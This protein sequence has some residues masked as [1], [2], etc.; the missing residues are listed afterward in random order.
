MGGSIDV[1]E[2]KMTDAQKLRDQFKWRKKP[3]IVEAFQ[4]IHVATKRPEWFKEALKN[5]EAR[6]EPMKTIEG[7]DDFVAV[8]IETPEGRMYAAPPR[9]DWIVKDGNGELR[10]FEADKFEETYEKVMPEYAYIPPQT[11]LSKFVEKNEAKKIKVEGNI[12]SVEDRN[13]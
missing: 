8:A 12:I 5:G 9:K 7:E 11:D 1:N 6:L 3:V 10:I 13:E 4:W 2:Y